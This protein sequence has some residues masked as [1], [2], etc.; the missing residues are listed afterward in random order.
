MNRRDV[1]SEETL[2]G[3][4]RGPLCIGVVISV[5]LIA[6]EAMAVAT[7]L[8]VASSDLGGV[9]GYGWA[10]SA[11]ML[12]NVVGTI[13]TGQA[14]DARGA[15][16]PFAVG[17]VFF[18]TGLLISGLAGSWSTFVLGRTIQGLGGGAVMTT[19]YLIVRMGFPEVLRARVM[20]LI[21][22]AWVLPALAGPAI[23][24]LLA[25]Y[26][27]WRYVFLGIP[28]LLLVVA[29]LL[30]PAL[31]RIETA[32]GAPFD[33]HNLALAILLAAGVG[34]LLAGLAIHSWP[35]LPV[36]LGG[37]A[38]ALFATLRLLPPG[39][40][41][42]K[43]GLPAGL[44]TRGL[45]SFC[46]F[47]AEAFLP[48][49]LTTL[50]GLSAGQAGLALSAGASTWTVGT[51]I[52]A[53][54]D[55][56]DRG[57]GRQGRVVGGF[58]LMLA[59][60]AATAAGV[61]SQSVSVPLIIACWAIGALGMGMVYPTLS[62]IVLGLAPTGQ[63]GRTSSSLNLAENLG[64]ALGTGFAGAAA[65]GARLW[66]AGDWGSV[67]AANLVALLPGLVGIAVAMRIFAR[68]PR[69]ELEAG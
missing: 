18:G 17:L 35:A 26:L 43:P 54:L 48:L 36:A 8:P 4:G 9:G 45:L 40:L 64:I 2:F 63:E 11:F 33:F 69:T 1:G 12:A 67:G 59:G 3:S 38:L 61:L 24:G 30:L 57:K 25:E 68:A 20:A 53:R 56:R 66:G 65:D 51:W 46:Y 32:S 16:V 31:R 41:L 34:L 21:S 6:F 60:L 62:V 13:A 44:G 7:I 52:Q 27:S 19:A 15:S 22:S 5:T 10:F 42:G 29:A 28:P 14:A 47:S 58:T 50:R 55:T 23:A 49:G 39:T 37:T